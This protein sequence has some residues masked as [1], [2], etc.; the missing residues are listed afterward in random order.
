MSS[1]DLTARRS[2]AKGMV[3][4]IAAMVRLIDFFQFSW[5]SCNQGA[6]RLTRALAEYLQQT[7][8][9]VIEDGVIDSED[10]KAVALEKSEWAREN[11]KTPMFH[12]KGTDLI[13]IPVENAV[14]FIR[15]NGTCIVDLRRN[16]DSNFAQGGYF[17]AQAGTAFGRVLGEGFEP[18]DVGTSN[19]S[20]EVNADGTVCFENM[21]TVWNNTEYR[22]FEEVSR[23]YLRNDGHVEYH[24]AA[25]EEKVFHV[26][27]DTDAVESGLQDNPSHCA[28]AS[29]LAAKPL[30]R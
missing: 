17:A 23:V 3:S 14:V 1:S 4:H 28:N 10:R 21:Y 8:V 5:K 24:L 30:I 16:A 19:V 6:L 18:E 15:G 29:E 12:I 7:G 25:D 20:L 2:M 9:A 26:L 22:D 11:W 27:P 13:A